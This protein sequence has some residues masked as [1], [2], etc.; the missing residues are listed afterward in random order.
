M[1]ECTCYPA[2]H[3][4]HLECLKYILEE[5]KVPPYV[6]ETHNVSNCRLEGAMWDVALNG[7]LEVLRYL[8]EEKNFPIDD[9]VCLFACEAPHLECVKYLH[10]VG[11]VPLTER[12][13]EKAV[14]GGS[15]NSPD[16]DLDPEK[17]YELI[18]YLV[19][20]AA[21]IDN[22]CEFAATNEHIVSSGGGI[23]MLQFLRS[24]F[25]APWNTVTTASTAE[26]GDLETLI[27]LVEDGCPV[28]EKAVIWCTPTYGRRY[29]K[30]GT[31][32]CLKYLL[33]E[34]KV[35]VTP[36]VRELA[37]EALSNLEEL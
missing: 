17:R 11:K 13:I 6:P 20:N 12:V 9:G 37:E 2:A 30:Q 26:I 25:N 21:P 4:G 27:Y 18:R 5:L 19:E 33:E 34:V 15:G 36:R 29:F 35:P 22:L 31:K 16:E 14:C 28:D 1:E 7:H 3:N 10:E 24:E 8:H 32:D 23:P